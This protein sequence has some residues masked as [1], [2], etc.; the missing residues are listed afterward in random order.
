VLGTTDAHIDAAKVNKPSPKLDLQQMTADPF[1]DA[2]VDKQRVTNKGG[3]VGQNAIKNRA[4]LFL[5]SRG[6]YNV[7]Y[8]AAKDYK[9]IASFLLRLDI[10][11]EIWKNLEPKQL[12]TSAKM[13]FKFSDRKNLRRPELVGAS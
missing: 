12:S 5:E 10:N 11:R 2:Q 1:H 6:L 9:V 13:S 8:T 7:V 3:L 4:T